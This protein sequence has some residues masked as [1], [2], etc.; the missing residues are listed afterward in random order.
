MRKRLLTIAIAECAC[1][2]PAAEHPKEANRL[3]TAPSVSSIIRKTNGLITGSDDRP[4]VGALVSAID[5]KSFRGVEFSVSGRDGRFSIGLPSMSVVVTATANGQVAGALV[6]VDGHELSLRLADP[7]ES[8][9]RFSGTVKDTS[10]QALAQVRVRLMNWN[11]PVGAAFYT[12]SD[13]AG[14]FQ[15]L[16]DSAG[17]YDLM[18]D[19]PRYVSNFAPLIHRNQDD[20]FLTAYGADWIIREASRVDESALRDLCTP[21]SEDGVRR[22]ANSLHSASVVGLGESTHGT[23]EFTELRSR[24]LGELTRNGWLTTI[25]LEASWEEV[26]HLDDYVRRRKGTGRDAVKSLAYWP[27][28]TEEFLTFVESVRELNDGLPPDRRIEFVGIDYAPPRATVDFMHHYFEELGSPPVDALSQL[29]SLRRVVNWSE[30]SKLPLEARGRLL[31]TLTELTQVAEHRKAVSLPIMQGLRITQLIIESLALEEDFRDRVMAEGVLVLLSRSDKKRHL[32]IWAHALH[33]AEDAIEGAIPMGH[34]LQQHLSDK[35]F[36]IGSMFYEGGFRTYSGLQE[37][38]VNHVATTPPPFY[39]ESAMHRV[40]PSKA[41][42]LDVIEATRR[43][44]LR[45]WLSLPKHVRVYGG[46]EISESYPW[47]PV[48]IRDLWSALIFAPTSTPT[49]P[50]DG[51]Q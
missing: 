23:R 22:F 12:I 14:R 33:I 49:T 20:A 29:D 25:A 3:P 36:A 24:I 10:G 48:V 4:V 37:K 39:L 51:E 6:P 7:S 41:C 2:S 46:L 16:V 11:W 40:S 9:R 17:S 50:L 18:V 47:P 21:L 30:A 34:Y 27:W 15:F 44:Q 31:R 26:V 28:R 19:D 13:Q 45:N 5:L 35:Y 1:S 38:M 32:A 8:T 43:P 42:V